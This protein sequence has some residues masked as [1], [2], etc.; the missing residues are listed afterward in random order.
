MSCKKKALVAL[1]GS[2]FMAGASTALAG[3][4]AKAMADTCAGCHGTDGQSVGPASPNLAGMSAV[5]F[6]DSMTAF[7]NLEKGAW[8]GE[9]ARPATI[10]NRIAKGYTDE[11]IE[12]MA[13]YFAAMPVYK[14]DVPHDAAKAKKGAAVY[15]KACSKC[16]DENGA[17]ADDD[18]GILAGQWL[19]W[20]QYSMQDFISGNREMP[21]KMKKEVKKL[22]DE[23]IEAS[24]HFF[25]SQK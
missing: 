8:S 1:I 5:Y 6:I 24:L 20:M 3:P 15:D 18:S 12:A 13:E 19:P 21:K 17:L 4:S 2:I 16:H 7:K 14:A 11:Q 25:A 22:S 10:M 23:E 9:D